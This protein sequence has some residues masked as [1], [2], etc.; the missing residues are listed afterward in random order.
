M[1]QVR[2]E[3]ARE[4]CKAVGAF[5]DGSSGKRL[6]MLPYNRFD[7]DVST[8]WWLSPRPEKAAF[9]Y[10]KFVFSDWGENGLFVGLHVEKG[11][12]PPALKKHQLMTRDW[13]WHEFLRAMTEGT[14]ASMRDEIARRCGANPVLAV[15]G[16]YEPSPYSLFPFEWQDDRLRFLK[17]DAKPRERD[18][19]GF[20]CDMS[21]PDLAAKLNEFT[22]NRWMWIDVTI[23]LP[24]E[25]VPGST[26]AWDAARLSAD[27]LDVLEPWVR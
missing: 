12:L 23:G 19:S 26:D 8:T 27:L 17:E 20:A 4:A 15:G 5:H 24:F 3:S 13:L 6:Y 1:R 10:G 16:G 18:L 7:A 14:L 21:L 22:T 11:L 25:V 9:R 2:F